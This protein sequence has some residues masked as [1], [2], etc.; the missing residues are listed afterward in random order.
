MPAPI[1]IT[2][3]MI[4]SAGITLIRLNQELSA[5]N[6]AAVLNC[7]TQPI[8]SIFKNMENFKLAM[9][10]EAQK[11]HKEK[12]DL[13]IKNSDLPAYKAYGMGFVKFAKDEKELFS[14]LYMKQ[15]ASLFDEAQKEY[16]REVH[17]VICKL[18]SVSLAQADQ[19]HKD[20]SIY[21][22][23]LAVM[24]YLGANMTEQEISERLTAEFKALY[25][26][27]LGG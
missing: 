6:I 12:I 17:K 4:L 5:R 18:Y 2:K 9:L 8:Y 11:I 1:K 23:G 13:Y 26:L 25:K 10:D 22:F 27:Y 3:E 20:M 14:F 7:S 16:Y 21:S 15:P 24:Q 19:F